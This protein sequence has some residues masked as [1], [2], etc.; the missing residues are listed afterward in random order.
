M[1][2]ACLALAGRLRSSKAAG[3]L[4]SSNADDTLREW[5]EEMQRVFGEAET[6]ATS[7]ASSEPLQQTTSPFTTGVSS[8]SSEA[9]LSRANDDSKFVHSNKAVASLSHVDESGKASMVDV[10]SKEDSERMAHAHATVLLGE[11]AYKAV[12]ANRIKKGDVLTVAQIAG[13]SAAK[14]ASSKEAYQY[15]P[16][17]ESHTGHL[18]P[19]CHPLLLTSIKVNLALD[20]SRHAV[21]IS[22]RVKTRGPTG[23]EMEALTAA[24]V[25]ALTVYDMCKGVSKGIQIEDVRLEAKSGGK[26]G[27][28]HR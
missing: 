6:T 27:D 24:A 28:W 12:E 1:R 26:S 9:G 3:R 13:I 25:S 18:I 23:V 22:T 20:P 11:E 7:T 15:T 10:S 21:V 8:F 5:N 14:Q 4:V 17:A 2:R 16:A 19:L